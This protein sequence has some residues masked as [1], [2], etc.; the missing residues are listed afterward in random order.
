MHKNQSREHCIWNSSKWLTFNRNLV[1]AVVEFLRKILWAA[2]AEG[3]NRNGI[4]AYTFTYIYDKHF[5]YS[6]ACTTFLFSEVIF[7]VCCVYC[8]MYRTCCVHVVLHCCCYAVC[9][10][11][12][13]KL[14]C[15]F[16]HWRLSTY[17]T[18][19]DFFIRFHLCVRLQT[20]CMVIMKIYIKKTRTQNCIPNRRCV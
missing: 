20:S 4:L 11:Y 12:I 2:T 6:H 10:M 5:V 14:V 13:S 17:L 19:I 7:N 9:V 8:T 16:F 3:N 15:F 1:L 18:V